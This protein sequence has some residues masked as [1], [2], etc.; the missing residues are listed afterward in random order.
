MSEASLCTD[1]DVYVVGGGNSAGQATMYFSR[2]AR[3]VA[4]IVR[5][6]SLKSTLS[7]YLLDRINSTPNIQVLTNTE[8]TSLCGDR[9][10]EA[11]TLTN[12]QTGEKN[13][14]RTKW[15]FICVGAEPR[16]EWAVEAGIVRDE[17]G[18]LVTGPDLAT[19]GHLPQNWPLSRA[20]YY[21]ETNVPGLFAAGDV[22]HDQ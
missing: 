6:S 11:I 1:E 5:G 18:Y 14:V 2:F 12:R 20:P 13:D 9:T 7:Y 22:R 21:L 15:L 17:G 16:T 19:D 3:K 8:V 10:L 4:M